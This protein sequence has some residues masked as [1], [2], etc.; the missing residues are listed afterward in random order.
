MKCII[1]IGCNIMA[2]P[3]SLIKLLKLKMIPATNMLVTIANGTTYNPLGLVDIN[4]IIADTTT[5]IRAL[6]SAGDKVLLSLD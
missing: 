6:L 4:V 1:D 3:Y 2:I 5:F